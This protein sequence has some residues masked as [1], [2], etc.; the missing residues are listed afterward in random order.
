MTICPAAE[1]LPTPPKAP[2]CGGPPAAGAPRASA[3]PPQG[4]PA[5]AAAS[6]PPRSRA[7]S[8]CTAGRAGAAVAA[9]RHGGGI[10]TARTM[11]TVRA[12]RP[13][14]GAAFCALRI[15]EACIIKFR[16]GGVE[17]AAVATVA[18]PRNEARCPSDGGAACAAAGGRGR[19]GDG[20]R[21]RV[22]GSVGHAVG[23]Q[24]LLVCQG[25]GHREAPG[26]FGVAWC[27]MWFRGCMFR[28]RIMLM[29]ARWL[30]A[31]KDTRVRTR[32]FPI[33]TSWAKADAPP[34]CAYGLRYQDV[35]QYRLPLLPESADYS[36]SVQI[37][38]V[39]RIVYLVERVPGNPCQKHSPPSA[40]NLPSPHPA[41]YVP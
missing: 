38:F 13:R 11:R 25:P 14:P 31:R 3:L 8:C 23:V 33:H 36:P 22:H 29:H 26:G 40:T 28:K 15:L 21:S 18:V 4:P 41:R 24:L 17:P 39:S 37:R 1:A 35:L 2:Q 12:T 30:L 9:S 16:K 32:T 6:T 27:R 19:P 5:S 7:T 34:R 10:C 20:R